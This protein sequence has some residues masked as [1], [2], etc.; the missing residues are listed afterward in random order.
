MLA[1]TLTEAKTIGI[2]LIVV[3]AIGAMLAAWLVSKVLQKV[4]FVVVLVVLGFA[5]WSQRDSLEDCAE[6]VE[7]TDE[8]A[9]C[10]FFG[11]DVNIG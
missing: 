4:A 10:T 6:R 3:L 11:R 8:S 7:A 1:L 9:T 2:V 5:V